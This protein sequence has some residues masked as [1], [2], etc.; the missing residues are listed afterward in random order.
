MRLSASIVDPLKQP[1]T[2]VAIAL[3]G[4]SLFNLTKGLLDLRLEGILYVAD[5]VYESARDWVLRPVEVLSSIDLSASAKNVL[6]LLGVFGRAY[7]TSINFLMSELRSPERRDRVA[8]DYR[9]V[10]TR[11]PPFA[12]GLIGWI[13]KTI[14]V[15]AERAPKHTRWLTRQALTAVASLTW[16]IGLPKMWL[17][18][19]VIEKALGRDPRGTPH[20]SGTGHWGSPM[21][22]ELPPVDAP[23]SSKFSALGDSQRSIYNVRTIVVTFVIAQ[24]VFALVLLAVFASLRMAQ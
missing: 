24:L 11:Y 3:G 9:V 1:G 15:L 4:L 17:Q 10:S 18:P 12:T 21:H 13:V 6:V 23:P 7:T 20:P 14:P 8:E 16:P 22:W 2:W 5:A 19:E